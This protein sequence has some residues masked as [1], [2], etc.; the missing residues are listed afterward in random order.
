MA[1][2]SPE[3]EIEELHERIRS[4]SAFDRVRRAGVR[5]VGGFGSYAPKVF[6]AYTAPGAVETTT[7]R[8]FTGAS[9]KILK[10]LIVDVAGIPLDDVW[11]TYAVK[12]CGGDRATLED[13]RAARRHL[14]AEW[15]IL[16]GPKMLVGVGGTAFA[17]LRPDDTPFI[18]SVG[19]S[20]DLV[21]GVTLWAMHSP[22]YGMAY[23]DKQDTVERQWEIM[24][25][26]YR[27]GDR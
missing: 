26:W 12:Y 14:R 20:V 24:G 2:R 21:N 17:S 3:I 1:R 10:S 23:P 16:G 7:G 6:V 11:M 8:P 22:T 9:G 25:A 4:D 19:E 18:R 13:T 5:L 15:A 27:G